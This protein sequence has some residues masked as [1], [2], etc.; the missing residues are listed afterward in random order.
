MSINND[1]ARFNGLTKIVGKRAQEMI[2]RDRIELLTEVV[3]DP[4]VEVDRL[5]EVLR[6]DFAT[7]DRL[8]LLAHALPRRE[9][10]WWACLAGKQLVADGPVPPTLAAAEAWVFKPNEQTREAAREAANNAKPTDDC[11][12]CASAVIFA[13]G[14]MGPGILDDYPDPPGA[15]GTL[16]WAMQMNVIQADP[17]IAPEVGDVLVERALDIARG[18]NGQVG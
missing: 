11:D 7:I 4:E 12:L 6:G 17:D 14:T 13:K 16:I 1:P 9:A 5:L 10:V 3:L 8:R 15:F 18:G 2:L